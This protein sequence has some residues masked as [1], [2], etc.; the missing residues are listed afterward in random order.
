MGLENKPYDLPVVEGNEPTFELVTTIFPRLLQ[1]QVLVKPVYFSNDPAQ[2]T[3]IAANADTERAYVPSIDV[4]KPIMALAIGSV[5]ES[6]VSHVPLG[7]LVYGFM[8]WSEYVIMDLKD[9]LSIF[10]T[11][12]GLSVTHFMGSLGLT[13]LTAYYGLYDIVKATADDSV[14]ISGAAGAVG[15]MAVQIARNLI[16][17]QKVK[18]PPK[19]HDFYN[20]SVG[21]FG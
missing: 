20:V 12:P 19:R 8:N 18:P 10:L 17:C 21:G 13:G 6:R 14:V 15:S 1:D 4:G 16:G 2:R 11:P 9:I 3:W 7:T 5:I